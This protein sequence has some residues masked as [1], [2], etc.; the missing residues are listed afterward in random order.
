MAIS[1]VEKALL[2][3]AGFDESHIEGMNDTER[4]YYIEEIRASINQQNTSSVQSAVPK[5]ESLMSR[6]GFWVWMLVIAIFVAIGGKIYQ[7]KD[8]NERKH[9]ASLNAALET[10]IANEVQRQFENNSD[11]LLKVSFDRCRAQFDAV[12]TTCSGNEKDCAQK[13]ESRMT[14][15]IRELREQ[16]IAEKEIQR[17][18]KLIEDAI[19]QLKTLGVTEDD[20]KDYF[21][22]EILEEE[23]EMRHM[24]DDHRASDGDDQERR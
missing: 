13:A 9:R 5:N 15:R 11:E 22:E 14:V 20:L 6:F 10:C 18:N 7:S 17:K 23:A 12:V 1:E 3:A 8:E 4:A 16:Q 2:L 21:R 19:G 24:M